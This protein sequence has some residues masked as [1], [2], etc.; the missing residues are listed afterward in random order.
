M[1]VHYTDRQDA[2]LYYQSIATKLKQAKKT[3]KHLETLEENLAGVRSGDGALDA[4][5]VDAI[6]VA[7]SAILRLQAILYEQALATGVHQGQRQKVT[8]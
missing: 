5:L 8:C 2:D 4:E 7:Q 6:N 1:G 3:L